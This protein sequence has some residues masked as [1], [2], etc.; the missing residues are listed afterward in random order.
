MEMFNHP[1]IQRAMTSVTERAAFAKR[2]TKLTLRDSKR[3]G[4]LMAKMARQ[5]NVWRKEQANMENA[6]IPMD[7]ERH[8]Q[9]EQMLTGL[10]TLAETAAR[11]SRVNTEYRYPYVVW[12]VRVQKKLGTL[13]NLSRLR[14]VT[15]H[16]TYDCPDQDI[17]IE[18]ISK[19]G[20]IFRC[21][22]CG[23]WEYVEQQITPYSPNGNLFP[24]CRECKSDHYQWS[25]HYQAHVHSDNVRWAMMPNGSQV[26][27]HEDD[28]DFR[29]DEDRDHWHHVDWVPPPPPLIGSYHSS[30]AHQR[31]IHDAWGDAHNDRYFGVEL[32]VE[33]HGG[34]EREH[35][36]KQLHEAIN[37]GEFGKRVF[38]END[39]SVR[40]GFEIISQPMS[41]PAQRELWLWLNNRDLTKELKS[42]NTTTCGLHVHVSREGLDPLMLAKAVTFVNAPANSEL[43]KSVARRYAEGY[44]KIKTNKDVANALTTSDRYEAV[45]VTGRRTV[46]F[47]IFKG[48]LKYESVIA[49][50]EFTHALLEFC[51]SADL[52]KLLADD[53][54]DFLNNRFLDETTVL[55]PY[56]AQRF[57]FA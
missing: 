51:R 40:N 42:H 25:E 37:G 15:R 16:I 4:N 43:I 24:V 38:F 11:D 50:I 3:A 36:A 9:L 33:Y 5:I 39:G 31:V 14:E 23:Q 28:D 56:L 17:C 35:K 47:R 6:V 44:C 8:Q 32:E 46:E 21:G 48:S 49:A 41:L 18:L 53:F 54:I 52:K 55:R 19:K 30:K 13:K 26:A 34:Y 20:E 22:D 12:L 45:N 29:Y 10:R 7:H 27:C 1:V 2:Y 57:E